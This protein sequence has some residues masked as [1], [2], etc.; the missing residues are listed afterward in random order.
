MLMSLYWAF[1]LDAVA[2]RCLYLDRIGETETLADL[3]AVI[4]QFRAEIADTIKP[5]KPLTM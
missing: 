2:R 1:D 5:W 4:R 3:I